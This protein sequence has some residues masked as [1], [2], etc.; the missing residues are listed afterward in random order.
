MANNGMYPNKRDAQGRKLCNERYCYE[1]VAPIANHKGRCQ[2]HCRARW[3]HLYHTRWKP[4]YN[5][6]AKNYR[7]GQLIKMAEALDKQAAKAAE[8]PRKVITNRFSTLPGWTPGSKFSHLPIRTRKRAERIFNEMC[9][10]FKPDTKQ[11]IGLLMGSA[12]A[13]ARR[14]AKGMTPH[15]HWLKLRNHNIS[16]RYWKSQA[17]KH[18]AAG[19]TLPILPSKVL[20]K[21]KPVR[22]EGKHG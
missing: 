10:R 21:A 15:D 17:R 2:K 4:V 20:D 11:R 13:K 5:W 12:T 3:R 6:A 18:L 14:E 16:A 9:A 22:L 8:D 19:G 7:K 1:V